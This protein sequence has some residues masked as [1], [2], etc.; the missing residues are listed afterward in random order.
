MLQAC[1]FAIEPQELGQRYHLPGPNHLGQCFSTD[2]TRNPRVLQEAFPE[3]QFY[4]R[5]PIRIQHIVGKLL[6][7]FINASAS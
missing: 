1:L 7:I 4:I 3:K 2:I 6:V 5:N